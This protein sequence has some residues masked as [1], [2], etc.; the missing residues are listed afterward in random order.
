MV[1]RLYDRQIATHYADFVS[2]MVRKPTKLAHV[3][4]EVF[5]HYKKMRSTPEYK[6]KSEQASRNRR[7][8]VGGPGSGSSVHGG[9][10]ISIYEH[11]LRLVCFW[12]YIHRYIHTYVYIRF[13]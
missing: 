12:A 3:Y 13:I 8:E 11:L 7:S 4:L 2:K 5:E 10:A 9:G 6:T 1:R